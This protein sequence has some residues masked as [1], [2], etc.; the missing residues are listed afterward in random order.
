MTIDRC[1]F[2]FLKITNDLHLQGREHRQGACAIQ[3]LFNPLQDGLA[4]F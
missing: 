2:G 3:R 4:L 1:K